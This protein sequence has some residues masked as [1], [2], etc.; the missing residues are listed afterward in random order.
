MKG[1][2]SLFILF[3]LI[4]SVFGQI[5]YTIP[6]EMSKGSLVGNIA[7]DLGLQ[8]SRLTSGK[9]R[10]YTR[11]NGEYIELNR[12]RGVLLVKEKIDREALCKQT[13]PC[14][15]HF[16]II[17][18]NPMEF[19]TATVQI[20]D[21]NDNAPTFKRSEIHFKISESAIVGAK[22]LLEAAVDHD[23]GINDLKSY[24]LKPTDNFVLKVHSSNEGD[25]NVE[26]VLQKPL[27]REKEEEISLVLTAVDGGEPQMSGTMLILIT[28]LDAND[29]APVFSQST[30]KTMVTENSP[31]GTVIVT[32]TAT[33]ADQSPNGKIMYSV[34]NTLDGDSLMFFVNEENGNVYLNG[35]LDFEEKKNYQVNI[36]ATDAG[37]LTDSCKLIVEVQ[38]VND[39][40]PEINIMSK[41]NVISEDVKPNTIVTM[42]VIED[43][44]SGENGK[45]QCF[46]S[47][48]VPFHLKSSTNN[49]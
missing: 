38:D 22:F 29:N 30:Y 18:E 45:V 15:L 27:D 25:K 13:T 49:F 4:C 31:K 14:A 46:T 47:D 7:N 10:I 41:S 32:V 28:V 21:V 36:I 17:L 5:S 40:K 43:K 1:L 12:E 26:M 8:T 9:A 35:K 19:F 33:D 3:L 42:I 34:S 44:D 16:Q 48:H 23:V 37:G 24:E 20:T 11:E 2:A 39:N 6:E